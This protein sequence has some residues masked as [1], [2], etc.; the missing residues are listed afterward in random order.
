MIG[1]AHV[2]PRAGELTLYGISSRVE[3]RTMDVLMLL[4]R[5]QGS[6]VS[7]DALIEQVWRGAAVSDDVV[8]RCIYQLRKALGDTDRSMIKTVPKRGYTLT[9]TV[10][11]A[12]QESPMAPTAS[13]TVPP[14]DPPSMGS[15]PRR[16]LIAGLLLLLG[17]VLLFVFHRPT[18][19][20]KP[21]LQ[22]LALAVSESVSETTPAEGKLSFGLAE[23]LVH[24]L[25]NA[26]ELT[27]LM[28]QQQLIV[29]DALLT[30][31]RIDAELYVHV[32]DEGER[33]R[34]D[35]RL[36]LGQRLLWTS[37]SNTSEKTIDQLLTGIV[38]QTLTSLNRP[39][40]RDESPDGFATNNL[41][42]YR[43]LLYGRDKLQTRN[44]TN[45]AEALR[46]FEQATTF[47]PSFSSAYVSI[48]EAHAL[49]RDYSAADWA[50]VRDVARDALEI[51]RDLASETAHFIAVSGYVKYDDGE[52]GLAEASLL[53]ALSINP[54]YADAHMWL[55]RTYL[56]TGRMLKARDA[57]LD[58][59]QLVPARSRA[60][61]NLGLAYQAVGEYAES[62]KYFRFIAEREPDNFPAYWRLA[63]T[64]WD[65]GKL[66]EALQAF[67]DAERAGAA[68]G[69][70]LAQYALTAFD[71][72]RVDEA[73]ALVARARLSGE[74]WLWT[75]RAMLAGALHTSSPDEVPREFEALLKRYPTDPQIQLALAQAYMF[76]G[77]W[78]QAADIYRTRR[79][80]E[81]GTFYYHFDAYYGTSHA[82]ML[83]IA[84]DQ[85]GE[86]AEPMLKEAQEHIATYDDDPIQA[87]GLTYLRASLHAASGEKDAAI[88]TFRQAHTEGWR[89]WWWFEVDPSWINFRSD[90]A[91]AQAVTELRASEP[92]INRLN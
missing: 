10:Q 1:N 84:L 15:G 23:D 14:I 5:E 58:T 70:F 91:L 89:H 62:V 26:A 33:W 36:T 60:V 43:L 71:S 31:P 46:Y 25:G 74:T 50:A 44:A 59:V 67:A 76:A 9:A 18:I 73:L 86:N 11:A 78:K 53:R 2:D 13:P 17:A 27:V 57:F 52:F 69:T 16:L 88:A 51:A 29:A 90:I 81:D 21:P 34:L 85:L 61:L 79:A 24:R 8:S 54:S 80:A 3:P 42:A 65:H 64:Y 47:A 55:G 56:Q 63:S 68:N 66:E 32:T 35:A 77:R 72:G 87:Y 82:L 12:A 49:R 30:T 75:V 45:I 19:E 37:T 92:P 41:E 38:N 6:V 22:N 48:A 4:V 28:K 83:A 20:T 40:S 39:P 7:R